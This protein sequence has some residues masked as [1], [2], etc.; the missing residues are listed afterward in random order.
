M[1]SDVVTIV[2]MCLIAGLAALAL[3]NGIDGV[4][5]AGSSAIIAGLGGYHVGK[6]NGKP[7]PPD[8]ST[9]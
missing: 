9:S 7:K 8:T 3:L 2:A 6:R 1:R 5:L 4:A